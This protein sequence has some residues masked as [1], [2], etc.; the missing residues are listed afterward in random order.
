MS[1]DFITVISIVSII[2]WISV[3]RKLEKSSKEKKKREVIPLMAVGV[4]STLILTL[5]L[6]EKL[7]PNS[8]KEEALIERGLPVFIN[9]GFKNNG[10]AGGENLEW[11]SYK[12][13]KCITTL[14]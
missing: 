11:I 2:I 8:Y 6:I 14:L 1:K 4:I 3:S 12:L 7:W 9:E 13:I 5:S 10:Q